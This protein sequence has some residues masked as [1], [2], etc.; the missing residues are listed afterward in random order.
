MSPV[1]TKV[2]KEKGK[3][4]GVR[5]HGVFQ[6]RILKY[7]RRNKQYGFTQREIAEAFDVSEQQARLTLMRLVQKQLVVR[8]ELPRQIDTRKG[9]RTT[10]LIYYRYVGQ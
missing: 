2:L 9:T 4:C 6:E 10:Y 3:Q 1:E 7:L 5:Q 8:E